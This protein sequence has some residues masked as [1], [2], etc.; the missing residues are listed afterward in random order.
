MFGV[1]LNRTGV[2]F[3]KGGRYG[4]YY[5]NKPYRRET[6]AGNGQRRAVRDW[7]SALL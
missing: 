1:V 5:S 7:I 6:A 4:G 3:G 2:G